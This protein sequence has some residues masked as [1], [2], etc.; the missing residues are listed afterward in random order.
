MKI[1]TLFTP[2]QMAG[3]NSANQAN[4]GDGIEGGVSVLDEVRGGS[5]DGEFPKEPGR[6]PVA[7]EPEKVERAVRQINDYLQVV[8][9][10]L[11]FSVDQDTKQVV[12][13]VIDAATGEVVRQIPPEAVLEMARAMM[14]DDGG[15]LFAQQA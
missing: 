14:K 8:Q 12:I 10:N 6:F 7:P 9:R 5:Q 1:E 3:P 13:K 4:R 2:Y 11:Q 15:L